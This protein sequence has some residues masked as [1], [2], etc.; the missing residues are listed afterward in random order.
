MNAPLT[1]D[2]AGKRAIADQMYADILQLQ[3]QFRANAEQ[4]RAERR[5]RR[6][7]LMH[8]RRRVFSWPCSRDSGVAMSW[9]PRISFVCKWR[10]QRAAC[11]QRGHRALLPCTRSN[12]H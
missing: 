6:P 7:T 9:T 11:R 3:D 12:W 1:V 5:V 10:S 8:C 2:T 4:A